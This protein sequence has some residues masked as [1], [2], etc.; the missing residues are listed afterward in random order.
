MH[1]PQGLADLCTSVTHAAQTVSECD[2][3]RIN[4]AYPSHTR[5]PEQNSLYIHVTVHYVQRRYEGS[6]DRDSRHVLP[7]RE[8]RE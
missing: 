2:S 6:I 1:A 3:H 4:A 5:N 8:G 7:T